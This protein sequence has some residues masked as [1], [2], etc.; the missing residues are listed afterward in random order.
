MIGVYRIKCPVSYPRSCPE[1]TFTS[2]IFHPNIDSYSGDICLNLLSEWLRTMSMEN[3][4]VVQPCLMRMFSHLQ[5]CDFTLRQRMNHKFRHPL[6]ANTS[7]ELLRLSVFL[8]GLRLI[9]PI[10]RSHRCSTSVSLLAIL[11]IRRN[12]SISTTGCSPAMCCTRCKA[13]LNRDKHRVS[14]R[15]TISIT[16]SIIPISRA[17][18]LSPT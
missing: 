14:V 6:N 10:P 11:R 1:V 15:G 8:F 4:M 9:V 3:S 18:L 7:T 5:I 17:R 16:M 2:P 13:I 12:S